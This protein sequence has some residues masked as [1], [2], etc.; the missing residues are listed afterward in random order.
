VHNQEA[1]SGNGS[2]EGRSPLSGFGELPAPLSTFYANG[3]AEGRSL[4]PGCGVSPQIFSYSSSPQAASQR[5]IAL[6]WHNG[7]SLGHTV[8]CATLG[9]ALL[10]Y[11]PGSIVV[12]ITGASKGFELLPQDMDLVK[13]PSYLTYDDSGGVRTAPVLSLAKEQFQRI[14]EN[15]IFTFIN[16]FQPHALVVDFHPEGKNG[17]LIPTVINSPKTHKVLGLRGILGSP[18]ETDRDFFHQRLVNFIQ[19]HF[20]A[21]HVYVDAHVI[22]LEDYYSIPTSLSAMFKYT[23]YVARPTPSTRA[24]ARALLQLDADARIFVVSFGGGQ[25]TEPIWQSILGS[26]STLQKH[27]DYAYLS[28]GP[29]L[30]ADAYE[31]LRV[32]V[33]QHPNWT[34]TRLL[35]PLPAWI[36][37]SNFFIGSGGY[38]SLTEV[39][40]TGT[41]ALIIP[42]QLNEQE[43]EL[44]ATKLARLNVFRI[45]NMDTILSKDVTPLLEMCLK[46]P[47]PNNGALKIATNGAQQGARLIEELIGK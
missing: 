2:A 21:I 25:G 37:A 34:W 12:G 10:D 39:I 45:A 23:G 9:Q 47:Y 42:R 36:K 13:I 6:Y 30:E 41:N 32:Q 14:R 4:L 24:Q 15:L 29:Y 7:R 22:R 17:E 8:R 46:E 44:H 35:N 26:L 43:Q 18:A 40:A 16:D 33:S 38:N 28:A 27:Y 19:D 31:R 11:L 3:S 5:R 1:D 20:S